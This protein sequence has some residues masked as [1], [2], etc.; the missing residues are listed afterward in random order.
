MFFLSHILINCYLVSALFVNIKSRNF[1]STNNKSSYYAYITSYLKFGSQIMKKIELSIYFIKYST[2]SYE[3]DT[4]SQKWIRSASR[5]LIALEG[6]TS[7]FLPTKV[8]FSFEGFDPKY[9]NRLSLLSSMSPY[10]IT[11]EP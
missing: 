6:G 1:G 10:C 9:R 4:L 5:W 11:W 3:W 2:T 8:K 7:E